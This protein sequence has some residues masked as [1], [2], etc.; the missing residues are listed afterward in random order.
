[1]TGNCIIIITINSSAMKFESNKFKAVSITFIWR[2]HIHVGKKVVV[3]PAVSGVDPTDKH[4]VDLKNKYPD[5]VVSPQ[6]AVKVAIAWAYQG[7]RLL[8]LGQTAEL[9]QEVKDTPI[10]EFDQGNFHQRDRRKRSKDRKD[11]LRKAAS[12]INN[13]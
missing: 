9:W 5:E 8:S 6:C 2:T 4:L 12:R 13:L 1:M 3:M 10:T 7:R 11:A